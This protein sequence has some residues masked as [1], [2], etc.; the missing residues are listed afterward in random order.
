MSSSEV[1]SPSQRLCVSFLWWE[2]WKW[3][4]L[5]F[6]MGWLWNGG[7]LS[8]MGRW[9]LRWTQWKQ[10]LETGGNE[11]MKLP[12]SPN[13]QN[14]GEGHKGHYSFFRYFFSDWTDLE[15]SPASDAGRHPKTK[16]AQV[17]TG[18]TG[19]RYC[20]TNVYQTLSSNWHALIYLLSTA[21]KKL[22]L[23]EVLAAQLFPTLCDPMDC[24][25]PGSSI[26]GIF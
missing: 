23:M 12:S 1:F 9:S 10:E 14:L 3:A 18:N 8:R 19:N 7:N 16:E 2:L 13:F 4:R 26:H 5:S 15:A 24:S 21:M 11:R 20:W 6:W 22:L 17:I 25:P